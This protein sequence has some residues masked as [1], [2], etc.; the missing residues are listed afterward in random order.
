MDDFLMLI[1]TE[2]GPIVEDLGG[3]I[4]P[5]YP[6]DPCPINGTEFIDS[7]DICDSNHTIFYNLNDTDYFWYYRD[8]INHNWVYRNA[9]K[10]RIACAPGYVESPLFCTTF[11]YISDDEGAETEY[12]F[13]YGSCDSNVIETCPTPTNIPTINPIHSSIVA[14]DTNIAISTEFDTKESDSHWHKSKSFLQQ[15]IGIVMGL[16]VT[17][18]C[19]GFCIC[20]WRNYRL[21][22]QH[23]E[24]ELE[25]VKDTIKEGFISYYG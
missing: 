8:T 24:V 25:R 23:H 3:I 12:K 11:V 5:F 16:L 1:K 7:E 22:R 9:G 14:T 2:D 20:G 18:C 15:I 21:A 13:K 19:C 10:D 6:T 17:I 4:K